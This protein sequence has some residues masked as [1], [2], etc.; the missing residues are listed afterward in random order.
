MQYYY[1]SGKLLLS[2]EYYVL[3]GATA[4]ALPTNYGQVLKVTYSPSEHKVLH[5][6]S[7]DNNGELWL[8]AVFDIETFECLDRYVSQKS[9]ILQKNTAY[10]S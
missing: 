3:D 4:L 7:Y 10:C 1:G 9:L 8:E 5:W 2:G 6:K